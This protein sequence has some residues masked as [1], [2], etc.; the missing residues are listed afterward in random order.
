MPS[1]QTWQ[2]F[3]QVDDVREMSNVLDKT[4][5][6]LQS[7]YA[8][9]K[10]IGNL[11]KF[12]QK[13]ID[14]TENIELLKE[15]VADM[16][17]AAGVFL[18]WW[19]ER[20]GVT[21]YI[22]VNGEYVRLDDDYYR[23][24]LFYRA[25]CNLSDSTCAT[26]NRMLSQLTSERIFVVDYQDMT[27]QSIVIIGSISDLMA[28]ILQTYGLLNRPAGVMTNFII[29]YPDEQIF[30]FEGSELQPFDQGVFNPGRTIGM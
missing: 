24:L 14:A 6:V 29:I 15:E 7:Q 10:R 4:S 3:L 12:F 8:A 30:G 13:E 25:R 5:T 23:F 1:F 21:R 28:T 16:E 22:K 9:S 20:V 19:G 17:S 18:D 2:D 26:M 11:G 27:L